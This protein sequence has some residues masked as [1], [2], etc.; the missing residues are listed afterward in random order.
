MSDWEW[1]QEDGAVLFRVSGQDA[2]EATLFKYAD[3]MTSARNRNGVC[4][5]LTEA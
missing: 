3:L 4:L 2:Y 1:M 5:Q